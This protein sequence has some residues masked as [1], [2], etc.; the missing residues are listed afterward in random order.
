VGRAICLG[1]SSVY[2]VSIDEGT[3]IPTPFLALIRYSKFLFGGKEVA[4]E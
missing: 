1:I 2:T 4:V 3:P